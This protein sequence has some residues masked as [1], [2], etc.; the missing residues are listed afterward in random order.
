MPTTFTKIASATVGSGGAASID[1]TSIPSTYT[2]L[3]LKISARTTRS[4][5]T[6]AISLSLNGVST[7]QTSLYLEGNGSSTASGSLTSFRTIASSATATASTFGNS[8]YYIPNYAG[9]NNKSASSDGVSENNASDA[10]AW[11]VANLW[12]QTAAITSISVT[13]LNSATFVQY[14][15]ATLYGIK[16]S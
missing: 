7:N 4:N 2:D 8:E 3:V 5:Y 1:F 13:D 15:T 14:T 9:S 11:L 10:S 12:S 16:K 6:D